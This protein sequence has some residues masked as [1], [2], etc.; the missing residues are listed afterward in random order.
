MIFGKNY[1]WFEI[2]NPADKTIIEDER[3]N[4]FLDSPSSP[5]QAAV[6]GVGDVFGNIFTW[7]AVTIADA[8]WY[9]SIASADGRLVNITPGMRKE[10]VANTF[11]KVLSWNNKQKK[12]FLPVNQPENFRRKN[13]I[14]IF[15]KYIQ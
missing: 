9:Q 8:S 12:E 5:L 1:I 11:A 14:D 10:Q 13:D 3:V 2:F 4:A 15:L 7:I 6:G